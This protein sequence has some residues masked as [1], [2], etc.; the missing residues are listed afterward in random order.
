[1][2]KSKAPSPPRAKVQPIDSRW[3][4]A[5]TP[6]QHKD[7]HDLVFAWIDR[8]QAHI[9]R[10]RE[11]AK[12]NAI[13]VGAD[14]TPFGM[15]SLP[16]DYDAP[17]QN[18]LLNATDT[19]SAKW[20]N[21]RVVPMAV[22]EG[23]T[24][25]EQAK[26]QEFNRG[27]EALFEQCGV[28]A[29]DTLWCDDALTWEAGVA[30]VTSRFGEPV[31]DRAF[32]FEIVVD[33]LEARYGWRG[34]RTLFHLHVM[35]KLVMLEEYGDE[36]D[37]MTRD[38][39]LDAQV[40]R[41]DQIL[42]NLDTKTDLV[43]VAEGWH[44]P[45]GPDAD[46]GKYFVGG[47]GWTVVFD[48]YRRER[49]PLAFLYQKKPRIGVWQ[50]PMV[51]RQ[52]PS[53]HE[54]DKLSKKIEDSH[55]LVGVARIVVKKGAGV[56]KAHLDDE[57]GTIIEVDDPGAVQE[58]TPQAVN[59]DTYNYQER[60]AGNVLRFEGV[61]EMASQGQVPAGLQNASGKAL[62]VYTDEGDG[63]L[64]P[65]FRNREAFLVEIGDLILDVLRDDGADY[66]V[67]IVDGK[68]MRLV[69]FSELD[70]GAGRYR[71]RV[72]PTS[73]LAH[74]P[75]AKFQQLGEMRERGDITP[76]EFRKMSG[77]PDLLGQNELDTSAQDIIDKNIAKILRDG[78]A[79]TVLPFDNHDLIVERGTKAVNLAR[80]RDEESDKLDLLIQYVQQAYDFQQKKLQAQRDQQAAMAA[81]PPLPAPMAPMPAPPVA[82]PAGPP[83]PMDPGIPPEAA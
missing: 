17:R 46:D 21:Q 40:S 32:A 62:Q 3:W 82:G 6:G 80:V 33:P 73:F 11:Q 75:S 37:P 68:Q 48:E 1:M 16:S 26:A 74:T 5:R 13:M 70:I 36:I 64:V 42:M 2:A 79:M 38:K 69:K 59:A 72:E 12:R 9:S 60:I 47:R 83:V 35:D 53:Q 41:D 43:V 29:N 14:V 51:T 25:D 78:R 49:F 54:H 52:A 77:V 34:V 45:S 71:L 19:V 65:S 27:I 7:P 81:P 76:I 10:R 28:F 67:Q 66:V 31:V 61:S 30:K 58:W 23:G 56:V 8:Q 39:I 50:Q 57:V 18:I 55:D 63:R 24:Y 15:T 20:S 4:L 44:L 22:T